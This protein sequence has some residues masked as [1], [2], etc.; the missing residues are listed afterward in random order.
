MDSTLQKRATS[1]LLTRE[2]L[3]EKFAYHPSTINHLTKRGDL[4]PCLF[5]DSRRIH[6]KSDELEV[7]LI[8]PKKQNIKPL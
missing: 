2:E 4:K 5:P 8:N 1:G 3:C 7:Y 6:Y